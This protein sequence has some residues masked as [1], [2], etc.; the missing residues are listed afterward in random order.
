MAKYEFSVSVTPQF[1]PEHSAPDEQHYVFAYTVKIRNT[2]DRTA[3]LVSRHWIITDANNKIEE[4]EGA[5]V[6]GEQPTLQPG[7]SFE[8]TSGC[9]LETP[10]GS[11]HGTYHCVGEDGTQFDAT[12]PEFVLSMPSTLH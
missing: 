6:I 7:Q 11:M 4:V 10:V 9:P 5:G 12:I 1:L 8:Y 2:G 3:T